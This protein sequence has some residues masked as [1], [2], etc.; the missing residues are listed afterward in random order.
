MDSDH[1]DWGFLLMDYKINNKD[2]GNSGLNNISFYTLAP[3][4]SLIRRRF[5][6]KIFVDSDQYHEEIRIATRQSSQAVACQS[7]STLFI[8]IWHM[9]CMTE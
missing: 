5:P 1:G 9:I 2:E 6:T 4:I 7:N 3:A 8:V